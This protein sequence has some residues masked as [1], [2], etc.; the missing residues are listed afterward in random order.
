MSTIVAQNIEGLNSN[1]VLTFKRP[2]VH[3]MSNQTP[4]T[5]TIAN[6]DFS[7]GGNLALLTN[8]T[9]VD[10][11]WDAN[12]A[13]TPTHAG[14]YLVYA[15][16]YLYFNATS[17]TSTISA[18]KGGTGSAPY[19]TQGTYFANLE[20]FEWNGTVSSG[21]IDKTLFGQHI[22]YITAGQRVHLRV[23]SGDYYISSHYHAC[24]MIKL[25]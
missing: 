13:M 16:T 12:G 14:L 24:G 18:Y 22:E 6:E 25:D 1:G 19:G 23:T 15:K 17:G 3:L 10:F 2:Q 21:R 4:D 7:N 9:A 20:T 5:Y 8:S 11:T